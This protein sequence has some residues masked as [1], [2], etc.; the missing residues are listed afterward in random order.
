[1]PTVLDKIV[2]TKWTEI[3]RSKAARPERELRAVLRDAPAVRDFF[4]PLA[5]GG[6]IKL[7]AE[8]KKAS[9]SAGRDSRRFR[10]GGDCTRSTK[11]TGRRA[12]AC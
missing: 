2:A 3:E 11:R 5:A 7:I 6:P 12:S 9:P 1:M 4:S 10:S 8:V